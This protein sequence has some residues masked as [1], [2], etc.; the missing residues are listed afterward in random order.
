MR[1]PGAGGMT[2]WLYV[3][4]GSVNVGES[5]GK[6]DAVTDLEQALPA[7]RAESASTLVVFFV[8]RAAPASTAGTISG[9]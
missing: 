7:V 8:D 3:M 4:D 1:M 9:K 2:P 5:L 6:G